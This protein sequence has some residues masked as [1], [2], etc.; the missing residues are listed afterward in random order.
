MCFPSPRTGQAF[1]CCLHG[2]V[3]NEQ[4][5]IAGKKKEIPGFSTEA[6]EREFWSK[7][8]STEYIDW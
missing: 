3:R 5:S 6:K 8:D 4:K 7:E 2:S 1:V